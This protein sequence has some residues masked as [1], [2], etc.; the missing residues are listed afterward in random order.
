MHKVAERENE[1]TVCN[2]VGVVGERGNEIVRAVERVGLE[3]V[4]LRLNGKFGHENCVFCGEKG[5]V[6]VGVLLLFSNLFAIVCCCNKCLHI[7]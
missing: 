6:G 7:W 1:L 4:L 3:P 5:S 2:E